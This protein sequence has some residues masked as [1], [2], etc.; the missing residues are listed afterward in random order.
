ML[1]TIAFGNKCKEQTNQYEE[2]KLIRS[3]TKSL[4]IA[5][6]PKKPSVMKDSST[7]ASRS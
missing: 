3:N 5:T 7:P 2:N 4:L 6:K 1:F